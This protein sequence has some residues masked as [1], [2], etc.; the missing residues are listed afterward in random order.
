MK[1]FILPSLIATDP[2]QLKERFDKV[3]DIAELFQLDVMDGKFVANTSLDFKIELNEDPSRFEAHLMMLHPKKWIEENCDKA[4]IFL[5]HYERCKNIDEILQLGGNDK[6]IGIAINP[7]TPLSEIE[8]Y[9]DKLDQVLIM[10]VHPGAYGAEFLPEMLEKVRELREK[11]PKLD[12]EVDGGITFDTL[13]LA[14]EAGANK[15][16]SGSYL[17]KAEN[18]EE[19][20]RKMIEYLEQNKCDQCKGENDG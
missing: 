20:Y 16:V 7:E 8:D 19:R 15:F 12:I 18:T 10:T 9:L 2:D 3:K 14:H 11:R 5:F 1:K 6:K 13:K 17:M 4:N